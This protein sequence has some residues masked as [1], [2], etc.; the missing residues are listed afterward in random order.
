MT[1]CSHTKSTCKI[2]LR[3]AVL[4]RWGDSG[5]FLLHNTE[6]ILPHMRDVLLTLP[7]DLA[8]GPKLLSS[9]ERCLRPTFNASYP[10]WNRDEEESAT[11]DNTAVFSNADFKWS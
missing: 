10:V 7:E 3:F 8:G 9:M 5:A 2:V 11:E 6:E 1:K 4:Q